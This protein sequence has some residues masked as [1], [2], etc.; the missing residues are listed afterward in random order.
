MRY[1]TLKTDKQVSFKKRYH[2]GI[3]IK[4]LR[5][6][7][8]GIRILKNFKFENSYILLFRKYFKRVAK[9]TRYKIHKKWRAW[10]FIK[11]NQPLSKKS[12][13]SRMGK[14]KG[15]FLRWCS[16]LKTGHIIIETKRIKF[17][18]FFNYKKKI[19][20]LVNT[21]FATVVK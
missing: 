16:K 3:K 15:S 13:N 19:E 1:I 11:Y 5:W 10:V 9:K 2:P 21:K 6:G 17:F 8:A 12:K 4:K 14:G 7:N 20:K 18:R